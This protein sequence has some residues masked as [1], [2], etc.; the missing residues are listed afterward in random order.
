MSIS[1]RK[2]QILLLGVEQFI[3]S[4]E[5]ITSKKL[6]QSGLP[7]SSATIRNEMLQLEEQG[8][9][10]QLHTSGGRVPTEQGYM[11][12]VSSLAGKLP[13]EN[14]D[15]QLNQIA[16][17]FV[18]KSGYLS[19]LVSTIAKTIA[20]VSN[21]PSAVILDKFEDIT[22]TNIKI[23][24]LIS[25][26]CFVLIE[27]AIGIIDPIFVDIK[28]VDEQLCKDASA[29]LNANFAG[30]TLKALI[31]GIS[32]ASMS[33]G[34]EL[35]DFEEI[36]L[37]VVGLLKQSIERYKN[38]V[39]SSGTRQLLEQKEYRESEKAKAL[40]DFIEDASALTETIKTKS[41][42]TNLDDKTDVNFG[43]VDDEGFSVV[44][45]TCVINGVNIGSLAVVGPQRMDYLK[46]ASALKHITSE[47]EKGEKK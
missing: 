6:E 9:L 31:D 34:G 2:K 7:Y 17:N 44:K 43:D 11:A 20:D 42:T 33:I 38:N 8:Y 10:R 47:L 36:F 26:Q 27:T 28:N 39:I 25:N 24:P 14:T 23:I 3:I 15:E 35:K 37:A 1:E 46:I 5:P 12:Y 4:A 29:C 19:E 41:R 16:K 21:L 45:S 22:I 30:H 32:S 13:F 18:T 40:L